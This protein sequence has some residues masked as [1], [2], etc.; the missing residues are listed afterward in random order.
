VINLKTSS[1]EIANSVSQVTRNSS[2]TASAIAQTKVSVDELKQI[3]HVTDD[4]AKDVLNNSQITFEI[5]ATSENLLQA[6]IND[7]ERINEKMKIITE[8]ILKLSE[9]NKTIGEIID[10]VNDLAEQSNLLAV[11]AAIEA[12]IAGEHG[13]SFAVV[14]KE[15][16]VLAEQSKIATQQI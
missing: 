13:K 4:K 15:I 1:D 14:A 7:M 11:N 6:T 5:V 16:R 3:A 9:H 12:A 10:S 2:D 8:C